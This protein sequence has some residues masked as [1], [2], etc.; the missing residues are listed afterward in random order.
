MLRIGLSIIVLPNKHNKYLVQIDLRLVCH[1]NKE[2]LSQN[3]LY[4][5]P[6][7]KVS[8]DYQSITFLLLEHRCQKVLNIF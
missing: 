4:R 6:C 7:V 5:I 2:L 8:M 1:V 3:L